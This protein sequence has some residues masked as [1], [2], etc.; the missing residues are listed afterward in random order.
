M[1]PDDDDEE[2][3]ISTTFTSAVT[4][5]DRPTTIH[6]WQLRDLISA[7]NNEYEFYCVEEQ[8]VHLYNVKTHE[9]KVMA[10]L[11]FAPNSMT[12]RRDFLAAGGSHGELEVRDLRR[13]EVCYKGRVGSTVNNALH[14]APHSTGEDRLYVCCNDST[15]KVFDLPSMSSVTV[16]RCPCPI[17]YVALSP[18]GSTLVAVGDIE[19]TYLYTAT[20]SGY[21]QH[22]TFT[23][24]CDVGMCCAWNQHGTLLASCH[25]DGAVAVWDA[26][27]GS[28]V[29]RMQLG[30]A[31]RCLK[32]SAAPLDLLAVSE[33]DE[34]VVLVD[35]RAWH[36]RQTVFVPPSP[37]SHHQG[38][39]G[40]RGLNI[41]GLAFTPSGSRLWV[42]LDTCCVGVD[43]DN[44]KR[45]TFGVSSVL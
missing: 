17:N 4:A 11:D 38:S 15:V 6:H 14:V 36:M 23:E 30:N 40:G 1:T 18:D 12:C 43:I 2:N 37:A 29:A 31:A 27:S 19:T 7:A 3:L 44:V 35:C 24:A 33:H 22:T 39:P 20:P 21:V 41:S 32:F 13:G 45:R 9:S 34:R 8:Q 5:Y 10:N 16:L 42:G 26:R 28:C 25:Q